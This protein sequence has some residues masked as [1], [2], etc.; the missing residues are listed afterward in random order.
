M[1]EPTYD[2][3]DDASNAET[4]RLYWDVAFG[5]QKVDG[6]EPSKYMRMLADEHVA[7]ER[8]YSQ[9]RSEITSYYSKNKDN[10]NDDDVE[11]ADIVST[12]IY[13]ILGDESFR[14][15]ILT[16]KNYHKRLFS[17]LDH[18][19]YN[20]GEFRTYNITK[21]EPIL[22]GDT[23]QYQSF[24]LI[25][26][27]LKY[28]FDEESSVDYS[29]FDNKQLV[30]RIA[31][32][33]SRIWQVHPFQ[34]GNT[35]TTA[36]FIQKYLNNMG[37][38]VNNELFKGNSLYFRN[39]LVRANYNNY[40]MGVKETQIY[41]HRFFENLLLASDNALNNDDMQVNS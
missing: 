11:E 26:E 12:A 23:V 18:K 13:E 38:K 22:N 28:D 7:N 6:L 29:Q 30:N 31:E 15:D 2:V 4:R 3:V 36:V 40:P 1:N 19:V 41:L 10:H 32:F 27:S 33:T 16:L 17:G 24:D 21:K 35:R 25:E 8:T 14:F 9:V 20:P 34:E 37:F 39:A 5:L